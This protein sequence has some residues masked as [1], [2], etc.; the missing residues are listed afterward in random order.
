MLKRTVESAPTENLLVAWSRVDKSNFDKR[1]LRLLADYVYLLYTLDKKNKPTLCRKL[2]YRKTEDKL[3][4]ALNRLNIDS[5]CGWL[6]D[7]PCI[8]YET[9]KQDLLAAL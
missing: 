1:S 7:V 5:Y 4:D 6:D 8:I 2:A 3:R 9:T